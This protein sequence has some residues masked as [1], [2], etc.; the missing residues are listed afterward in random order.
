M[1]LETEKHPG[2]LKDDVC[3]PEGATIYALHHLEKGGFRSLLIDAVEA[4]CTRTKFVVLILF[5][6]W[7][8]NNK[9]LKLTINVLLFRLLFIFLLALRSFYC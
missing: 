7:N 6:Y 3:S 1:L 9:L 4:S 2:E 8:F 5:V